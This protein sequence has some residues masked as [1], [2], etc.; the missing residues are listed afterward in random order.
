M[1]SSQGCYLDQDGARNPA[2]RSPLLF[3]SPFALNLLG[4]GSAPRERDSGNLDTAGRQTA[5][6]CIIAEHDFLYMRPCMH[7]FA[8]FGWL[9]CPKNVACLLSSTFIFRFLYFTSFS[10]SLFPTSGA[11]A[12]LCVSGRDRAEGRLRNY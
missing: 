9:P 6:L 8:P 12:S 5:L 10:D 4:A 11:A 1:S 7:L 2:S 3:R